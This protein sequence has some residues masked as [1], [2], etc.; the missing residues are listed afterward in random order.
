MEEK[1]A[2]GRFES[3]VFQEIG[4]RQKPLLTQKGYKLM[5]DNQEGNQIQEAQRTLEEK[6]CQPECVRPRA[7]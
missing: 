5:E 3:G 2:W 4:N 7:H 6:P 1:A